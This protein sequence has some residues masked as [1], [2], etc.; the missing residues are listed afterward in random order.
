MQPVVPSPQEPE[1][2]DDWAAEIALI[3]ASTLEPSCA[4]AF[5]FGKQRLVAEVVR[6]SQDSTQE[7]STDLPKNGRCE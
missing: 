1:H 7:I 5:C 3:V 2:P 4:L 6:G